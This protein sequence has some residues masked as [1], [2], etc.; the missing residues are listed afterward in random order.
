MAAAQIRAACSRD[1]DTACCVVQI[2]FVSDFVVCCP[3]AGR[4]VVSSDM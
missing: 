1:P 2:S 3:E 4:R